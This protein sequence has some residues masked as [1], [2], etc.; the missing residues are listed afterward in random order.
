MKT[1]HREQPT[2]K[3]SGVGGAPFPTL[4]P[5]PYLRWTPI[6]AWAPSRPA[7]DA[8]N[9]R[10]P[11]CLSVELSQRSVQPLSVPFRVSVQY[12]APD[13]VRGNLKIQMDFTERTC[14]R[15][16]E[17]HLIIVNNTLL[18]Q[19]HHACSTHCK[20]TTHFNRSVLLDN[21]RLINYPV[22]STN[23]QQTEVERLQIVYAKLLAKMISS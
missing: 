9:A 12:L 11:W 5:L 22:S 23:R 7:L 10:Q 15:R 18:K 14:Q 6:L 1:V 4:P 21:F 20:T 17:L 2:P 13:R 3:Y 16:D 19:S 8:G